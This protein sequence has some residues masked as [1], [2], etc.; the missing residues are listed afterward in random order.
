MKLI[1]EPNV[2]RLMDKP[3]RM[4]SADAFE[5]EV[6]KVCAAYGWPMK[7]YNFRNLVRRC[8]P[9]LSETWGTYLLRAYCWAKAGS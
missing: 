5:W 4:Y 8:P 7:P 2:Q 1:E 3:I 9:K 6:M